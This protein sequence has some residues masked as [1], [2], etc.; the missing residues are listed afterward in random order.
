MQVQLSEAIIVL[1]TLDIQGSSVWNLG[2]IEYYDVH[3][4]SSFF[5]KFPYGFAKTWHSKHLYDGNINNMLNIE[6]PSK[7][8]ALVNMS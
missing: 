5:F 4:Q 2:H 7:F 6:A 3:L 1:L 8:I